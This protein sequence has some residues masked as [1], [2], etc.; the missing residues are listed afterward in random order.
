MP[1]PFSSSA[2]TQLEKKAKEVLRC[3]EDAERLDQSFDAQIKKSRR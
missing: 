1:K 2:A 3:L